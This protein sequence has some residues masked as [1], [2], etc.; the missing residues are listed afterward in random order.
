LDR[1]ASQ[2]IALRDPNE[3]P[4]RELF[5]VA[6]QSGPVGANLVRQFG[7][8]GVL[9]PRDDHHQA[10]LGPPDWSGTHLVCI[11]FRDDARR[12]PQVI[13]DA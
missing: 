7:D 1:L 9:V 8:F 3:A 2:V 4:L 10:E 12:F 13:T 6:G 11:K 5:K